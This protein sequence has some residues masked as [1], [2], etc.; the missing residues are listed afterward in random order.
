MLVI[1]NKGIYD[2]PE[3]ELKKYEMVTWVKKKEEI[4]KIF[5]TLS[6]VIGESKKLEEKGAEVE[7]QS[8]ADC[9]ANCD[10]VFPRLPGAITAGF[11]GYYT[12]GK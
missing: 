1:S 7:G 4:T 11:L 8:A 3:K 12:P 5:A 2:V 6:Q 10:C 9:R